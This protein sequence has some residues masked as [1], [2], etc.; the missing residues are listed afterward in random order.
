MKLHLSSIV[1]SIDL[2]LNL[3]TNIGDINK[4]EYVKLAKDI[5]SELFYRIVDA[6]ARSLEKSFNELP[7]L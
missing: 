1:Q 6:V 7:T 2:K 4:I 3:N 5:D